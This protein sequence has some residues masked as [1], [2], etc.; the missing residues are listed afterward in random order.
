MCGL[1]WV[2]ARIAT[3]AKIVNQFPNL[4]NKAV[5]DPGLEIC[6]AVIQTLRLGGE[7]LRLQK[8]FVSA[9]RPQFGLQISGGPW[10]RQFQSAIVARPT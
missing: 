3:L 1:S 4:V 2:V 7:G 10:I 9:L 6:G 8:K 5:A